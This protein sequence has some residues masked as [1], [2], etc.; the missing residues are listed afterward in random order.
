LLITYFVGDEPTKLNYQLPIYIKFNGSNLTIVENGK[1]VL[2]LPAVSGRM[3]E[4]G[5]FDYSEE[6]QKMKS[7]GPLPEGFYLLNLNELVYWDD[8]SIYQKA[9]AYANRGLFP[10]GTNAWGRARAPLIPLSAE[11]Y[12]RSGFTVHG[13]AVP[14]SAGCIDL[15]NYELQFFNYIEKYKGTTNS[16]IYIFVNYQD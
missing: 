9:G 1:E 11:T 8:L 3:Q 13:G 14:G 16:H 10:G 2:S 15:T 5:T 7:T 12:G 4:D 6:R